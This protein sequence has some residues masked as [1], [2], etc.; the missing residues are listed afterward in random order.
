MPEWI[1]VYGERHLPN[2]D[3]YDTIDEALVAWE[4]LKQT[5]RHV[6]ND[7]RNTHTPAFH[8]FLA[9]VVDDKEYPACKK[10]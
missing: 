10:T 6:A 3:R 8:D 7:R 9:L 5:R 4:H 2:Y 1:L